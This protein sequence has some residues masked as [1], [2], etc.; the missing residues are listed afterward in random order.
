MPLLV[1][2]SAVDPGTDLGALKNDR[3]GLGPDGPI[4]AAMIPPIRHRRGPGNLASE[5]FGPPAIPDS[6][7]NANLGPE[8][9]AD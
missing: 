2:G 9:P 7:I 6:Q 5:L 3:A 4:T 8:R 1:W